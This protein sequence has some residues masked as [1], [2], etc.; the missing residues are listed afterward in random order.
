MVFRL[1]VLKLIN[2]ML[3]ELSFLIYLTCCHNFDKIKNEIYRDRWPAEIFIGTMEML[4]IDHI[5][6]LFALVFHLLFISASKYLLLQIESGKHFALKI[7]SKNYK[8]VIRC[9]EYSN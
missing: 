2:L 8:I 7:N 5:A 1:F 6:L 3:N 9:L 4:R